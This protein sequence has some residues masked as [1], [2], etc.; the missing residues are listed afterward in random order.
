MDASKEWLHADTCKSKG[1]NGSS[2]SERGDGAKVTLI[3]HPSRP[4]SQ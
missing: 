4:G 2:G 3:D 1:G